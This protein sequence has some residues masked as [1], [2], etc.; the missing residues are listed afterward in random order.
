MSAISFEFQAMLD[1]LM[2]CLLRRG[3][4]RSEMTREVDLLIVGQFLVMEHHNRIAIYRVLDGVAIGWL[5][6]L[7]EVDAGYLGHE[8]GVRCLNGDAHDRLLRL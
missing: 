6:R 1:A 5:Q 4:D 3:V 7:C 2:P 8:I